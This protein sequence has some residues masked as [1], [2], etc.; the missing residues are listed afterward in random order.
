MMQAFSNFISD[1][2]L[3]DIPLNGGIYT[4]S[5]NREIT[6]RSKIDRFLFSFVWAD[7]FGLVNQRRLPRLLSDHFPILLDCGR[8]IGGKRPFRFENM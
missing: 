4:W 5:N 6:S 3:M 7:H 8:V 1:F 2:S